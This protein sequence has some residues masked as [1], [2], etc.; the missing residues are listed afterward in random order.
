MSKSS[1]IDVGIAITERLR[2]LDE[3]IEAA[4]N[5]VARAHETVA[6]RDEPFIG[7]EEAAKFLNMC[8][9]TLERRMAEQLGP[10]RYIDGGKV[11]FRRSEL[12]KWREKWRVGAV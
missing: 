3:A 1:L 8:V 10:P 12:K 11:N 5:S 2:G 4:I 7:K 9:G 6:E